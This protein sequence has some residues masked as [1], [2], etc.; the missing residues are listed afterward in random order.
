M[1]GT[2]QRIASVCL[3]FGLLIMGFGVAMALFAVPDSNLRV[4]ATFD[5]SNIC[6]YCHVD[7]HG[8]ESSAIVL[9]DDLQP[10][11]VMHRLDGSMDET[12]GMT[13]NDEAAACRTCHLESPNGR[14]MGT[15]D[16][17]RRQMIAQRVAA[18]R[19]ELAFLYKHHPQWQAND[20]TSKTETQLQAEWVSTLIA[21]IEADNEWGFHP[22]RYT[23]DMLTE[24]EALINELNRISMP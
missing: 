2:L 12:T 14:T 24:A 15:T 11:F 22:P 5:D 3:T 13:R 1:Q 16:D 20:E 4:N 10:A 19:A 17:T 8:N 9:W 6:L 7:I 21:F 23:D 18:L